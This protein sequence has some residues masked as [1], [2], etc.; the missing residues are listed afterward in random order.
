VVI[1]RTSGNPAGMPESFRRV[2]RALDRGIPLFE[3]KTMTEHLK[4][5]AFGPRL[6][7]QFLGGFGIL[8]LVLTSVGLYGLVAFSTRMRTREIGI[9]I[10]LG[11]REREI[12]IMVLRKGTGLV[13]LGL[14]AGIPIASL[15][16]QP[17]S[18]LLVDV[19]ATD[20]ITFAVVA[21]ILLGVAILASCIP[22][23]RAAKVDPMTALRSE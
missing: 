1:A 8:T 16:M 22:A 6:T 2:L 17:M 5:L 12:V 13:V 10:A 15:V 18:G 20:P 4:I 3:A 19:S 7:A 9:R 23:R 11:A 21:L 14:A